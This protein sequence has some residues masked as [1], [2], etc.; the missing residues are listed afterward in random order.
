[1]RKEHISFITAM[2]LVCLFSFS[3][4]ALADALTFEIT[5]KA[6]LLKVTMY[7]KEVI[8][9][10]SEDLILFDVTIKNI[11]KVPNLYSVSVA[12]PDEGGAEDFIPVEGEQKLSPGKDG[13]TSVGV[14]S[15]KFPPA[16]YM[17]KIDVIEE[18]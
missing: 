7:P 4:G 10:S 3:T 5:P 15:K 16:C 13:T 1:M 12:I 9:A 2:A 8:K 14:V 6:K 17:I 11:D 18:R